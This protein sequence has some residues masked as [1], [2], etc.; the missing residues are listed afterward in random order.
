MHNGDG[1][2]RVAHL[3]S[4]HHWSDTRIFG[5]LCRTLSRHGYDVTLVAAGD[6]G[7]REEDGVHIVVEPI[8]S[9]RAQRL[10]LAVPRVLAAA[11]RADADIYH[12]HD[13]ELIPI[14]PLLRLR[15]AQVVYDAH[16]DLPSQ[17]LDKHYLPLGVRPVLAAVARLLCAVADR[18]AHQIVAATPTIAERFRSER[19]TVVHNYPE[20][21]EDVDDTVDYDDRDPAIAYVGAVTAVRCATEMVDAM[22]LADLPEDW[23]LRLV[24][25]A[26]PANLRDELATRPGWT[27]VE[28]HGNVSP[29]RARELTASA[30]I[31]LVLFQP[32]RAHVDALPTKLFEYMAAGLPIVASDFPVWRTII[33]GAGCGILVD[34]M[35]PSAIAKAL[36]TLARDPAGARAM[37]QNG[38]SA[39]LGHMNWAIEERNLLDAYTRLDARERTFSN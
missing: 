14:I 33:D 1:P 31:G 11:F 2:T 27:L 21:L 37:G 20:L 26:S 10:L 38:R 3:S 5:R 7:R 36:T 4:A 15:G 19:C 24:G 17:V 8:A 35:D 13:P 12:L 34:P 28:D 18:S 39:V 23:R 16:E 30:R 22:H 6:E 32:T 9:G 29:R 25:P